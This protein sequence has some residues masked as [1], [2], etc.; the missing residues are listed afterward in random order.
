MHEQRRAAEQAQR[1][2]VP[3]PEPLAATGRRHD[4]RD[5]RC[6]VTAASAAGLAN[7]IRPLAVVSTLVTRTCASRPI[8]SRARSTTTIVPSSR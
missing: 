3:D 5:D 2:G 6:R 7:T 4:G 1:L 8:R